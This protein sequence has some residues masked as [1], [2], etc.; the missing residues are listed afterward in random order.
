M[1]MCHVRCVYV[2]GWWCVHERV[3]VVA[4]VHKW[5]RD[6]ECIWVGGWVSGC[7]N[8]CESA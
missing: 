7:D 3:V 5:E 1:A 4:S 6:D 2:E 8:W